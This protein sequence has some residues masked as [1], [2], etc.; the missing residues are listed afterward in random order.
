MIDKIVYSLIKGVPIRTKK[1]IADQADDSQSIL[2]ELRLKMTNLNTKSSYK[3]LNQLNSKNIYNEAQTILNICTDNNIEIIFYNEE[4]Y[5]KN[6]IQCQDAPILI[7]CKGKKHSNN[8]PLLSIVGTRDCS[9]YG[10]GQCKDFISYLANYNIGLVSGLAYGIDIH[11][12]R[13]ANQLDIPNYAVLGS[14]ILNIY[15][16]NHFTES[17]LT[18]ENGMIISEFTPFSS[19]KS[20][21][22]PQRNR[23]IAG[24]SMCTMVVESPIK[25][26]A[27]ITA[28]LANDYNRDVFAIPGNNNQSTSKGT[29]TLIEKNQAAILNNPEQIIDLLGLST[30]NKNPAGT[31]SDIQLSSQETI[32][33]ELIS[34]GKDISFNKIQMESNFPTSYLNVILTNLE[35]KDLIIPKF[36]NFYNLK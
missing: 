22:F 5:P 8:I 10:L 9:D 7:Y 14:G 17:E 20:Y 35:L 32:I 1:L 16:K 34:K 29:N 6:L 26:G 33:Y 4:N 25:G 30:S 31:Q 28:S 11:T 2:R 21:H 19:P 12:H 27:I 18:A 13:I 15:P 24:M 36:G 23:I 3:V